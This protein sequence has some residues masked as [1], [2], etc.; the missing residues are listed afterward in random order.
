MS[1][2]EVINLAGEIWI[3]L[4]ALSFFADLVASAVQMAR[5]KA[6]HDTPFLPLLIALHLAWGLPL[7]SPFLVVWLFGDLVGRLWWRIFGQSR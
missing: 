3:V 1:R 7:V 5:R 2:T 6:I 4:F